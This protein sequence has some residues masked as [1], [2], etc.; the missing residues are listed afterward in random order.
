MSEKYLS[1]PQFAERL[2]ISRIAVFKKI[3]KGILP[4]VQI[5]RNWA[6]DESYLNKYFLLSSKKRKVSTKIDISKKKINTKTKEYKEIT[7]NKD[8]DNSMENMG[9]D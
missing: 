2:G 7:L 3:K 1:V 8:K 9:W 4:A 6:L 5:G